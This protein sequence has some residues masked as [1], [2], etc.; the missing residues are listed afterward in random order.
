MRRAF[1]NEI[2]HSCRRPGSDQSSTAAGRFQRAAVISLHPQLSCEMLMKQTVLHL[3]LHHSL[4]ILTV[5]LIYLVNYVLGIPRLFSLSYNTRT[6][7]W[8]HLHTHKC[9]ELNTVGLVTGY[10]IFNLRHQMVVIQNHLRSCHWKLF[11]KG[12]ELS[13]NS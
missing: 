8:L 13:R 11:G 10:I 4:D 5:T 2:H 9:C 7:H 12:Q 3:S 6:N 1:A